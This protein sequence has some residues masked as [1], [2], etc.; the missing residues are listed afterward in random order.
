MDWGIGEDAGDGER[1]AGVLFGVRGA[2]RRGG[3]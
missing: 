3:G 2:I 1:V